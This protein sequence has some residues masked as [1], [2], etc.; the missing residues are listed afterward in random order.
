M[1]IDFKAVAAAALADSERLVT[2]W[3][4]GGKRS[5]DEYF[6]LNPRRADKSPGSFA[7][8]LANGTWADFASDDRGGDLVSLYACLNNCSQTDAAAAVAALVGITIDTSTP[9]KGKSKE[10]GYP[11]R[12][13][14][15]KWIYHLPDG[16]KHFMVKRW[17]T[18]KGKIV[19][20]FIPDAKSPHF[21]SALPSGK[22]HIFDA[23]LLNTDANKTKNILL[24]EGEMTMSA[25]R[26]L[27]GDDHPRWLVSCWASGGNAFKRVEWAD[28]AGRNVLLHP[29]N[30]LPGR[31]AMLGAARALEIAGANNIA[32]I[33]PPPSGRKR[34][35]DLANFDTDRDGDFNAWFT[36]AINNHRYTIEAFEAAITSKPADKS[37]APA[38]RDETLPFRVIGK[39]QTE[40]DSATYIF[41]SHSTGELLHLRPN[42]ITEAALLG[43]VPDIKFWENYTHEKGRACWSKAREFLIAAANKHIDIYRIQRGRGVWRDSSGKVVV[44]AGGAMWDGSAWQD[45]TRHP[46]FIMARHPS[47]DLGETPVYATD[48]QL[49]ESYRTVSHLNWTEG[50]MPKF[51]FGWFLAAPFSGCLHWRPHMVFTGSSGVGKSTAANALA[52]LFL[53]PLAIR[54]VGGTT[55]SGLRRDISLNAL[56]VIFDEDEKAGDGRRAE[57]R[58]KEIMLLARVASTESNNIIKHGDGRVYVPRSMFLFMRVNSAI[59]EAAN[60]NR[61][62]TVELDRPDADWKSHLDSFQDRIHSADRNFYRHAFWWTYRN[63]DNWIA[64]AEIFRR[65]YSERHDSPR[66]GDMY[67]PIFALAYLAAN[68]GKQP[69]IDAAAAFV[70]HTGGGDT[71]E[72][73]YQ[74]EQ[75]LF[76]YILHHPIHF[77]NEGAPTDMTV[78]SMLHTH[79]HDNAGAARTDLYNALKMFGIKVIT[80]RDSS[81]PLV[82]FAHSGHGINEAL[83]RTRWGDGRWKITLARLPIATRSTTPTKF[84]GGKVSSNYV[85]VPLSACID[86]DP[87]DATAPAAARADIYA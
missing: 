2:T 40:L 30:D 43:L 33:D 49:F 1:P 60:A 64:A 50:W 80:P 31:K 21:L 29:D 10:R 86:T 45:P 13:A 8:N 32:I 18:D 39:I 81:P 77:R 5:G 37:T 62:A 19:R 11:Q 78:A 56:P 46:E 51:V 71:T 72:E 52:N 48:D 83:Q 66:K 42:Q 65:M 41:L 54:L 63:I 28:L 84:A 74:D 27:L 87:T 14:D 55:E 7:I 3:L 24:V 44:H 4:P 23:H 82:A 26:A 85:S 22:L 59:E 76:E 67:A 68:A 17:D 69:T 57:D 47:L 20:P 15:F 12:D 35:W 9:K 25:A 73:S 6:P 53:G 75:Q 61:Y 36:A 58:A 38:A 70:G 34:G 16:T 79:W